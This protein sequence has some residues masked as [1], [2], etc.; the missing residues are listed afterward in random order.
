MATLV[1]E[2]DPF[3]IGEL[4]AELDRRDYLTSDFRWQVFMWDVL[5]I[6]REMDLEKTKGEPTS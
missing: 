1:I 4:W 5:D 2:G 6:A 3:A